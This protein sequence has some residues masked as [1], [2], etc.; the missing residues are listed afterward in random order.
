MAAEGA[1]A[2]REDEDLLEEE[3][4]SV[5]GTLELADPQ[6]AA[7]VTP[8]VA[9]A[10]AEVAME[11]VVVPTEVLLPWGKYRDSFATGDLGTRANFDHFLSLR[12]LLSVQQQWRQLRWLWWLV[13][14]VGLRSQSLSTLD[15]SFAIHPSYPHLV[16]LLPLS[17]RLLLRSQVVI[18]Q[19]SSLYYYFNSA[20]TA[21]LFGSLLP[22]F[23]ALAIL[24][25]LRNSTKKSF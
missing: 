18:P 24:D 1:E 6:A 3:V 4:A 14:V 25:Y 16:Q 19:V 7:L 20:Y 8:L 15:W 23:L 13:L 10:E 17:R 22:F 2:V 11:E 9:E 21:S 5:V 12:S